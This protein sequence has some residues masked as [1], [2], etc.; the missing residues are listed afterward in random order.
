MRSCCG[1]VFFA[2][3]PGTIESFRGE[4]EAFRK[5]RTDEII[6]EA[7]RS[8]AED[9]KKEGEDEEIEGVGAAEEEEEEEEEFEAEAEDNKRAD[10][11]M[12]GSTRLGG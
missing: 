11:D 1:G 3:F 12:F 8:G 4:W 5:G 2:D 9:R 10:A 6:D 7:E